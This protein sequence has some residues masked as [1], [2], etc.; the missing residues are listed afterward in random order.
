MQVQGNDRH[1]SDAQSEDEMALG[2]DG[3]A[4][5]VLADVT[6]RFPTEQLPQQVPDDLTNKPEEAAGFFQLQRRS[7][8]P[9]AC[10]TLQA[11]YS[12]TAAANMTSLQGGSSV[13]AS[14]DAQAAT[15]GR[16]VLRS[17]ARLQAEAPTAPGSEAPTDVAVSGGQTGICTRRQAKLTKQPSQQS[18][19]HSLSQ[20]NACSD[21]DFAV[22]T[23]T[24]R[25][26][27]VLNHAA[28]SQSTASQVPWGSQLIDSDA[29][30]DVA[31]KPFAMRRNRPRLQLNRK[32]KGM[33]DTGAASQ[34]ATAPSTST[35]SAQQ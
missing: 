34:A 35:S 27:R 7:R 28:A 14:S 24:Q 21:D 4:R 9:R 16:P 15:A 8:Q 19:Q 12:D 3:R 31:E 10:R 23:R 6:S 25:P 11:E 29:Q 20:E 13:P 2:H 5:V 1:D 22:V 26:G 17:S 33:N 18:S 32:A 30:T